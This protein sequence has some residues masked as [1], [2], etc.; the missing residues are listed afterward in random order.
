MD[1]DRFLMPGEPPALRLTGTDAMPRAHVMR[2]RNASLPAGDPRWVLAVR[3]AGLLET[4][5][6][7]PRVW[8]EFSDRP[9]A[10][11]FADRLGFAPHEADAIGVI[12]LDAA[13]T[14]YPPLAALHDW[15]VTDQLARVRRPD[16]RRERL[17]RTGDGVAIVLGAV[18]LLIAVML[19]VTQ[20]G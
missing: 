11:A 17:P 13:S 19:V 15:R 4:A 2:Q 8:S 18:V 20:T 14:G 12:V 7:L 16:E 6:E 5:G 1:R 9:R 3:I 10:R